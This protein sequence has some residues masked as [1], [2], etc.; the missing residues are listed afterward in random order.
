MIV[1][2]V[3]LNIRGSAHH[4]SCDNLSI[5]VTDASRLGMVEA[6]YTTR[7]SCYDI[8]QT[9]D[10]YHSNLNLVVQPILVVQLKNLACK[11][12]PCQL[13]Q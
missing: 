8:Y 11:A 3:L 1:I 10:K 9:F 4:Y 6:G 12:L 2:V 7:Y 5:E 13:F